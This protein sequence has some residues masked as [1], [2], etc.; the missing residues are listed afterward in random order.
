MTEKENFKIWMNDKWSTGTIKS[1]SSKI[2]KLSKDLVAKS[3]IHTRS[4][5]EIKNSN[6]LTIIYNNW[7]TIPEFR[8]RDLKNRTQDSNAFKRYIEFRIYEE[9]LGKISNPTLSL[10]PLIEI[11]EKTE[12]YLFALEEHLQDFLIRNLST[13]KKHK[14]KLYDDGERRGKEFPTEVGLIDIL[15]TD[16]YDNFYVFETK[17]SKGMD[18]ALGQLLRYMGWVKINLA[19]D[20][21]VFGIIVANKMDEKIKYA[22]EMTPNVSLCEYEM[23]FDVKFLEKM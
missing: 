9:K 23:K 12:S 18:K 7:F 5:Y 8:E 19:K 11:E 20:K 6:D 14:L 1:Y 21:N 2:D 17:L 4:L 10:T 22:V 16:E 15:T 3:M 13:I